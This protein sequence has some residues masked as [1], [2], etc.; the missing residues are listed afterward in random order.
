MRI[1]WCFAVVY[2]L[3]CALI[4]ITAEAANAAQVIAGGDHDFPP[5]EFLEN[6]KPAGF[7]VDLIRAVAEV[8]D[9]DLQIQLGSWSTVKR[10]LQQGEIDIVIGMVYAEH[11][12][13]QFDFSVPHTMVFPA[14]FVRED[15]PI[16]QFSDIQGK[17]II[18][19]KDDIM[20]DYLKRKGL[21]SQIITV[22]TH[23]DALKLLVAGRYDGALL[24]SELHKYY[25]AAQTGFEKIREVGV[26]L[27]PQQYCFGLTEGNHPLKYKLDKGLMILKK[28]GMYQEIY[29]KWFGVYEKK[30]WWETIRF[31]VLAL[32]LVIA[33]F[34]VS[35]LWTWTLRRRVQIKTSELLVSQEE[36]QTAHARLEQRVEERTVDLVEANERLQAEITERNRIEMALRESEEEYRAIVDG[37]DGHIY[38]CSADRRIEFMNKKLM[39]HIGRD[40]TGEVCH[41]AIHGRDTACIWCMREEALMG[42]TVRREV[43]NP[44]DHRWYYIV[45]TPIHHTDGTVSQQAMVQDITERIE[46]EKEKATLESQNL[47]LQKYESLDRMASA[48]AHHFNNKLHVV[49]GH[50]EMALKGYSGSSRGAQYLKD[51]MDAADKAAEVSR[52]MLTYLGKVTG[53]RVPLDL[54][55]V[56][57]RCISGIQ[58]GLPESVTIKTTLP[59][60]GP[61]VDANENQIQLI[62]T[63]ILRN[64]W[65]ALNNIPGTIY[66]DISTVS[67]EEIPAFHRFPIRWQQ[68]SGLYACLEIRDTGC[69]IAASDIEAAFDPFF[70]T[71]FTGRGLGLSVVLGLVQSHN[72]AVTLTSTPGKGSVVR[73]F[74]P[75]SD[76]KVA[77]LETEI[78]MPP[79]MA[80]KGTILLVDDDTIVLTITGEMLKSLGYKVVVA[81]DG[82]EGVEVYAEYKEDIQLIVSDF[83]MPEMNGLEML[84]MIRQ[85]DPGI[86]VILASGYSEE[87]VMDS[88]LPERPQ[89]FLEKPFGTQELKEAIAYSLT[90]EA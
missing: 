59:S 40:A 47:Q 21:A 3:L 39:D 49:M 6:G 12:E 16:H 63:N 45:N 44:K 69:G 72:G 28:N 80:E 37:F 29:N 7:N 14:L 30:S 82:R 87:Q 33:F 42:R 27:P 10:R 25:I 90:H 68:E 79:G 57:N 66:V 52:L 11:R 89:V 1:L 32:V 67:P 60:P 4:T 88:S 58:V 22:S 34:L 31:F 77:Y 13:K 8:V 74:F 2:V 53:K 15:S 18:V 35:L 54:S 17:E 38:I 24:S 73:V 43:Q 81:Q 51:A 50:L 9:L 26:N 5:F 85:M 70:S 76:E 61:P 75:I 23:P 83:A 48:I 78:E 86:P 41:E 46:A 55:E 19:Q 65:E 36:L 62:L 20:H 84:T 56:C 71:K 64:S